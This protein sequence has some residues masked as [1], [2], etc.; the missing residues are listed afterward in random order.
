M[1]DRAQKIADQIIRWRRHVHQHPELSFQEF[2]TA[3][4][5]ARTLRDMGIDVQTGVAKTGVVGRLGSG[6]PVIALRADMDALPVTEG[7]GLPFASQVEGVMHACGHDTHVACLLGAAK[8][9]AETP[10][11]RGEVRFLFQPAEETVDDEG[12][13]GA[14]RMADEGAI[15]GVDAIFGLHNW[16]E[17]EVGKV[18]LSAGPQMASAGKFTARIRGHGGHGA[19]PHQTVDPI[20]LASQ[21]V[22]ALQT[23]V[24]RRLD[25]IDAG[26]V[27]VGSVHG[28]TRDNIIPAYVDIAGTLRSLKTEVYEQLM[29]EVTR[30]LGIARA[31]GGD[32]EVRFHKSFPVTYNDPEMTAFVT[33]I[34]QE[35]LGAEQVLHAEP[36]MGGEDF[37]IFAQ[38]APGCF[39]RLGGGF[40]GQP[41]RNH[42]DPHFDVDESALPIGT[43]ML[44]QVALRYLDEHK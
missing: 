41:L 9:L 26:V 24:S 21:A 20:V 11:E 38:R 8:L 10:P 22:L 19:S 2:E 14:T 42:H 43:A 34:A 6:S 37:S 17:I 33:E 18:A 28:G 39:L 29:H 23:I 25:P 36:T 3:R 27:T 40:P 30:A 44:A 15:D 35:M 12:Q 7:T 5:V 16:P 32:F 31:L 4:F 13:S 1:L